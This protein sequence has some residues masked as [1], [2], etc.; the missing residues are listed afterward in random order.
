VVK[1]VPHLFP[2]NGVTA[3]NTRTAQLRQKA[4]QIMSR[5]PKVSCTSSSGL[6]HRRGSKCRLT[7]PRA[8]LIRFRFI[9]AT[10]AKHISVLDTVHQAC[11]MLFS[12]WG[13]TT[14]AHISEHSPE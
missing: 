11:T 9:L 14:L 2:M 4:H 13:T 8:S 6:H 12:T 1:E 3:R 7:D 10:F 5:T